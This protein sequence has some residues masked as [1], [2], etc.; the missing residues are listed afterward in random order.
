M[1]TT[2]YTG[3]LSE[4]SGDQAVTMTL[5]TGSAVSAMTLTVSDGGEMTV[6]C[7]T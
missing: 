4:K 7:T 2:I 3:E 1:A 5:D 6:T